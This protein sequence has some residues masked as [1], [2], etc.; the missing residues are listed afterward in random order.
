MLELTTINWDGYRRE[1]KTLQGWVESGTVYTEFAEIAGI[2][3]K[4]RE[5]QK[6]AFF[7][8]LFAPSSLET[9]V[10]QA[11]RKTFPEIAKAL[12]LMKAADY[13]DLARMLQV[14]EGEIMLGGVAKRLCEEYP[15][16]VFT[17]VHDS[18]LCKHSD[19]ELVSSLINEEYAKQGINVGLKQEACASELDVWNS[20]IHKHRRWLKNR[21]LAPASW[22]AQYR[23]VKK[24]FYSKKKTRKTSVWCK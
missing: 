15:D 6:T 22:F 23:A 10:V 2:A 1:L 11:F 16:I 12:T 8:I 5:K 14:L 13:K 21:G 18:I 17:T 19:L 7:T 4:P 9:A 20:R 3:N 24:K